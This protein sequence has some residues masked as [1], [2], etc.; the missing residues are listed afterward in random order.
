MAVHTRA[1]HRGLDALAQ[2]RRERPLRRRDIAHGG[3][4]RSVSAAAIEAIPGVFSMP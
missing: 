1:G 4:A 3:R 2:V